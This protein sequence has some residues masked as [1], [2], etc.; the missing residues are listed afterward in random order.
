MKVELKKVKH[1]PSLSEET[2]AF[3]ADVF[4]NGKRAGSV[5]NSGHGGPNDVDWIGGY[6]GPTA[7][8]FRD[9]LLTLPPEP[10]EHFPEGLQMTEDLFFSL[11]LEK[12]LRV[13]DAVREVK[14]LGTRAAKARSQGLVLL[15]VRQKV[16]A[17]RDL[18]TIA[19]SDSDVDAWTKK[20]LT[21]YPAGNVEVMS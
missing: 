19:V 14:L 2:E 4:I 9:Y 17:R 7:Q 12:W 15:V 13:K 5:R 11:L 3:T 16:N 1:S 8:V 10:S 18:A 20:L 21:Q 6:Q